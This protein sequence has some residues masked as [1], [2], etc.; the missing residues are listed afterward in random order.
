[1][2]ETI[3]RG[4]IAAIRA[5]HGPWTAMAID[6]PDGTT[7]R[8]PAA[9][10]RLRRLVQAA[11]DILPKPLSECRVLDLACLEGHY[12]I[13]FAA[14]GS[15]DVLGV[16]LR[17]GHLVKAR[18]AAERLGL[19]NVRFAQADVR[20][21]PAFAKEPFDLVICSGILYHLEGADAVRL[22]HAIGAACRHLCLLDT[23]V[24]TKPNTAV[25]VDGRDYAGFRYTEHAPDAS[26]GERLA[27]GWASVENVT[28]L[29]LTQEALLRAAG[30]GGFTTAMQIHLPGH[31]GLTYDRRC[32]AFLRGEPVTLRTSAATNAAG[33]A[34]PAPENPFDLSPSQHHTGPAFR[35]AKK[36]LPQGVK[37]A[38]KPALRSAGVLK[39]QEANPEVVRQS[40]GGR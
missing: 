19:G 4:D 2:S 29:W 37:N 13:E 35:L 10:H 39:T 3:G 38:I 34:A 20:D 22:V 6:L 12:A 31:P 14:R 30:E 25:R 7:T 18:F 40:A 32:Y 23:Y 17:E 15:K 26:A 5:E 27:D 9:D 36:V 24:G 8:P 21:L 16:D 28:S 33:I 11:E 1:M